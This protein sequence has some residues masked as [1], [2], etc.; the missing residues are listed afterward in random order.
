MASPKRSSDILSMQELAELASS[1][2]Q[3]DNKELE[4]PASERFIYSLGIQESYT[5]IRPMIIWLSFSEWCNANKVKRPSK[6]VFFSEFNEF[7]PRHRWGAARFYKLNP[8]P[9]KLTPQ[10]QQKYDKFC[11]KMQA[12][13]QKKKGNQK[14]QD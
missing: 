6:Q 9:F 8:I 3:D 7:F 10:S 13:A 5:W 4:H 11:R 12:N 2:E 14:K 1:L